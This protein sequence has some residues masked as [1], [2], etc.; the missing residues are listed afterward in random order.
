MKING[1]LKN[2]S[3]HASTF[4]LIV[5]VGIVAAVAIPMLKNTRNHFRALDCFES[6]IDVANGQSEPEESVCRLNGLPVLAEKGDGVYRY[7]LMGVKGVFVTEPV[8]TRSGDTVTFDQSFPAELAKSTAGSGLTKKITLEKR[9]SAFMLYHSGTIVGAVLLLLGGLL[10]YLA[11][12]KGGG[13]LM[14]L[15]ILVPILFMLI[16]NICINRTILID[17]D[18]NA[19]QMQTTYLGFVKMKPRI[20]VNPMAVVPV[21]SNKYRAGIVLL[22][23]SDNILRTK[24]LF[25]LDP[26]HI[27][28]LAPIENALRGKERPAGD[29]DTVSPPDKPSVPAGDLGSVTRTVTTPDVPVEPTEDAGTRR[30][31]FFGK[32]ITVIIHFAVL[33]AGGILI[34]SLAA[35][36]RGSDTYYLP[37]MWIWIVS[38]LGAVLALFY[39]WM[40]TGVLLSGYGI[41]GFTSALYERLQK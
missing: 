14:S 25:D 2:Q 34:S 8:F 38:P 5:I 10:V 27:G 11:V 20:F 28:V 13:C 6:L 32:A 9:G 35:S 37:M 29:A 39:G 7:S 17:P 41:L 26:I 22:Y 12:Y 15:F 3:G 31:V 21:Q 30:G 36:V 19:V 23:R 4:Y 16:T 18:N 33:L 40:S 1:R 24:R